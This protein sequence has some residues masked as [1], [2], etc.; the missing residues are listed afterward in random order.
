MRI[1]SSFKYPEVFSLKI[2]NFNVENVKKEINNISS[3]KAT[4]KGDIPV[5]ILK[6]NFDIISPV[7]TECYSQN[8]KNLTFLNEL[9]N[10]DISPVYKKKDH[11][12][13]SNYRP[14]GILPL[15]SKPFERILYEQ[16]D[17]YTK[18][19][20]FSSQ[21]SLLAMFEK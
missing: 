2:F 15:L 4:P 11:H 19:M 17:N 6:W 8:I 5:K 7:L 9:K 10:A 13:K 14:V 21:H 12:D 18:D 16:I 20:L 1:K 3:K